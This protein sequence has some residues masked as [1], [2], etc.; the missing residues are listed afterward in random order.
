MLF[1]NL[2]QIYNTFY[3]FIQICP[4]VF[5]YAYIYVQYCTICIG[6]NLE[7]SRHPHVDGYTQ[8]AV[9]RISEPERGQWKQIKFQPCIEGAYSLAYAYVHGMF[10]DL[11]F[12]HSYIHYMHVP[13]DMIGR[14]GWCVCAAQLVRPMWRNDAISGRR[15][16]LPTWRPAPTIQIYKVNSI[17]NYKVCYF[18]I[19]GKN[20]TPSIILYRFVQ[21]YSYTLIYTYNIALSALVSS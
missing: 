21:D 4:R 5:V 3:Y 1:Y 20:T 6:V 15:P 13:A 8:E 12:M 2:S 11:Q 7:S 16:T 14:L 18:I 10:R 19:R 9:K 17:S